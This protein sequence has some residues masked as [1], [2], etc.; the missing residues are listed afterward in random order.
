M[1]WD[2]GKDWWK[3]ALAVVATG[4]AIATGGALGGAA[5]AAWAGVGAA[6]V[7]TGL[8]WASEDLEIKEEQLEIQQ[9]QLN[10]QIQGTYNNSLSDLS[11]LKAQ[12]DTLMDVT[13]PGLKEE[14]KG[15]ETKID[16]WDEEYDLQTGQIQSEINTYDD[17]LA[18]WETSYTAQTSSAEEQGRGA[19]SG[20]LSNWSDAE[21]LAADRGA[22]GSMSLIANQEKQRAERYAGE[23]LSLAG[24]DGLFGSS[25]A[26]LLA[27]LTSQK[28]QYETNRG[29]L[30]QNLDLTKI[31]LNNMLEDWQGDL[32]EKQSAL[33]RT[34]GQDN[35]LKKQIGSTYKQAKTNHDKLGLNDPLL[36]E[37]KGFLS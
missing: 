6:T 37:Y 33:G 11:D 12:Y 17:L 22:G 24:D 25:Y 9:Q 2:W 34:E 3:V 23:D 19:L 4:A 32:A 14:I 29:L 31:N 18:S 13:I 15:F 36:D 28:S 10:N 7:G 1:A 20:L 26:T 27:N 8:I 30:S 5:V 16:L 35:L 21:V